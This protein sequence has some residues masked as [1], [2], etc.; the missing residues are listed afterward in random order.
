[1]EQDELIRLDEINIRILIKDL[2]KNL[3]F[4]LMAAAAGVLVVSSVME[5]RYKPEYTSSATLAVMARGGSGNSYSNLNTA[6]SMAEVLSAVFKSSVMKTEIVKAAGEEAENAQISATLIPETN[7]FVLKVTAENPEMTYS[8]IQTVLENY[9]SVSDYVFSNAV[10]EVIT[11]P[12]IPMWPSNMVNTRKYKMAGAAVGFLA[13]TALF[14]LCSLLRKTV[15]SVNEGKRK[16]EGKCIG[17]VNHE[18]KNRT[19]LTRLRRANKGLLITNPTAGFGFVEEFHQLAVRVDYEMSKNKQK[20]LLVNSVAENE[21]KTTV[22]VNLALA[23]ARRNKKVILMDLDLHKPAQ[24]KM[25]DLRNFEENG[26]LA[27]LRGEEESMAKVFRQD[28]RNRLIQVL[29]KEAVGNSLGLIENDRLKWLL[30]VARDSVDYVILD[31]A[32]FSVATDAQRINE[33]CDASLLV[34]RQDMAQAV[35]VNDTIEMLQEGNSDFLGYVL[36]DFDN[37]LGGGSGYGYG[38]GRYGRYGQYKNYNKSRV[39][40]TENR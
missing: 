28:E 25:F 21:G 27:Y 4:I 1:M 31:T 7:L 16:I 2:L 35:D 10:I 33:L 22:A 15:K 6:N 29:N 11:N 20:V 3:I 14:L 38:Y 39:S 24:Y 34:V 19:I 12:S 26:L 8:V 17:I 23:L 37:R 18:V 30:K 40:N 9:H 13:A 32:P 5:W 36:N